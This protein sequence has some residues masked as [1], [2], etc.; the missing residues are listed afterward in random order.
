MSYAMYICISSVLEGW[1]EDEFAKR[2]GGLEGGGV[3]R[4]KRAIEM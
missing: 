1:A 2:A 4:Q 3:R